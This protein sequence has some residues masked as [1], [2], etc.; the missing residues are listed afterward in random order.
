MAEQRNSG[1][2]QG[3]ARSRGWAER[4]RVET[5]RSELGLGRRARG[6]S[7]AQGDAQREEPVRVGEEEE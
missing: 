6:R 4:G 2:A 7:K 1:R 3:G 5:A